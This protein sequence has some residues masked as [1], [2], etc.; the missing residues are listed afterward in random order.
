MGKFF[1]IED[2]ASDTKMIIHFK[3]ENENLPKGQM[4]DVSII[5]K[6]V[7]LIPKRLILKSENKSFIYLYNNSRISKQEVEIKK[8]YSSGWAI[9][10]K[11]LEDNSNILEGNNLQLEGNYKIVGYVT[12]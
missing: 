9:I 3:S 12:K 4:V 11:K 10:D 7:T 5:T 6:N 2:S 1:K 8:E